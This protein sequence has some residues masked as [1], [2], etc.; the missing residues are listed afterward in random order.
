MKSTW[1]ALQA[2]FWYWWD[3]G[4]PLF[5]RLDT[6]WTHGFHLRDCYN[7]DSIIPADDPAQEDSA[8]EAVAND[9]GYWEG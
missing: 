1:W 2:T 8:R 4:V 5:G 9:V 6:A 3:C 7:D